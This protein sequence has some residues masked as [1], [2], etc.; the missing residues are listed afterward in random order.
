MCLQAR[1]FLKTTLTARRNVA[2]FSLARKMRPMRQY[3]W[4]IIPAAA[5]YLWKHGFALAFE[6]DKSRQIVYHAKVLEKKEI[7]S[8]NMRGT[9]M[10]FPTI[11]SL[12]SNKNIV[13]QKEAWNYYHIPLVSITLQVPRT[14]KSSY[15]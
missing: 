5:K 14:I 12:A 1:R 6:V 13:A 10:Y 3:H 8:S 2:D 15:S 4:N 9:K 11:F 7:G